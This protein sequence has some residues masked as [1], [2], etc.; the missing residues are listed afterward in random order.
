MKNQLNQRIYRLLLMAAMMVVQINPAQSAIDEALY[1]VVNTSNSIDSI[2]LDQLNRIFSKKSKAFENGVPAL[3]IAQKNSRQVTVY[4]NK[5]VMKKNAQQLK[6]YWSRKMFSGSSK[7]PKSLSSDTEVVK[8]VSSL[9]N[10][11]GYVS[12]LP[13]DNNVKVIPIK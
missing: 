7:P 3:P 4:F 8:F 13:E 10:A 5:V 6:Y 12:K 1:I 11:I 2:S 9:K